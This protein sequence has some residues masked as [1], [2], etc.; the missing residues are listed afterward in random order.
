MASI[1]EDYEYHINGN[2]DLSVL[3]LKPTDIEKMT[4]SERFKVYSRLYHLFLHVSQEVEK[5]FYYPDMDDPRID[6]I[7]NELPNITS[8]SKDREDSLMNHDVN[9]T[10]IENLRYKL[11]NVERD[12]ISV[13]QRIVWKKKDIQNS[14][15]NIIQDEKTLTAAQ[16][17]QE[18]LENEKLHI[19]EQI[20]QKTEE[21]RNKSLNKSLH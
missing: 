20:L 13:E 4:R 18:K 14:K 1:H 7:L 11:E 9:T 17:E 2:I 16:I 19:L 5:Y 21:E 6:H 10:E 3:Q 8:D 12:I 15:N